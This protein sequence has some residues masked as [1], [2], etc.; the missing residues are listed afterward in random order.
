MAE[1]HSSVR[2]DF[3][4]A[5]PARNRREFFRLAAFGSAAL[6]VPFLLEACDTTR[7]LQPQ[8][9]ADNKA[10]GPGQGAAP[11][12]TLDFSTDIGVAN[13]AYALEQLE[14]AFYIRVL[15]SP[16][17]GFSA[18]ELLVL[19]DVRDHEIAHR[20]FFKAFLGANAIPMLTPNFSAV[21]FA[22]VD[23]VLITA[24]TFEDLGVAA[25]N[26]AAYF[27]RSAAVLLVAG[28][29][30]SV[31]A[32]HA[33]T[34]RDLLQPRTRYFAGDDVIN[35]NGLD[36]AMDPQPVLAMAKPFIVNPITVTGTAPGGHTTHA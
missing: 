30:V 15:Q 11:A 31:E 12:V 33:A 29:I 27:I 23:N 19:R 35:A 9:V 5:L 18:R 10:A 20:D 32:R 16:A 7:A 8:P 34:I 25:Y 13:Y 28:K 22:N 6:A 17:P 4:D 24:R 26:G 2:E 1:Q 3:A 14:A 36:R 21:N